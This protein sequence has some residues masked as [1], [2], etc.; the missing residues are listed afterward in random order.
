MDALLNLMSGV[1]TAV[2]GAN[3]LFILIGA[4]VGTWVG[5]LPGIGPATAIAVLLPF[6]FGM[7]PTSSLIMLSGIYFGAMYGGSIASIMLNI[8]G[9]ASSVMSTLDGYPMA[10]KGRAGAALLFSAAASFVGGTLGLI[11]LT[12]I[13]EPVSRLAV[14]L[15][16]SEYFMLMVFALTATASTV[17]GSAVRGFISVLIGLALATIGIDLQSGSPRFTFGMPELAD[18]V[19][20]LAAIIGVYAVTEVMVTAENLMSG[21]WTAPQAIGKLWATKAEWLRVRF[22]FLRG[23]A[24]GF[25][26]GLL[27]G[28]GGAV[29]TLFAYSI[30]QRLSSRKEEFGK[31]APEGLVAPEA[32]NNASVSGAL[33]PLLTLGIPGSSATAVLLGALM[34]Y[35]I[36]PGPRLF[37]EQPVLTWGVIGGLYVANI[38]LLI[39]NVPLI[40]LWVRMLRVPAAL[41]MT[42]IMVLAVTGAFSLSNS[43]FDVWLTLGFGALGYLMRKTDIPITPMILGLV[44]S[45]T[46]EQSLRQSLSL[47]GSDWSVFVTRPICLILLILTVAM[48]LSPLLAA[49]RRT[50]DRAPAAEEVRSDI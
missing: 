24:I 34:M 18:G 37:T 30:E 19:P 45:R 21:R 39:L 26:V 23:A 22:T 12:L 3:L 48:I 49:W 40:G 43:F 11:G 29:A 14:K 38:V 10:Q 16:P 42:I 36:Q 13:A 27:P 50:R 9:D 4:A 31:G 15:G 2:S 28:A 35:G 41:M 46:L 6:T 20:L 32:A 7:D 47:S 17:S 25:F 1:Q 33:V 44:L 5:M 8:P